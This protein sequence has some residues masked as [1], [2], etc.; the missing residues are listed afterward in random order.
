M[1]TTSNRAS[2]FASKKASLVCRCVPP[3]TGST[4]ILRLAITASKSRFD[5]Q[6]ISR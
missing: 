4:P 1:K 3:L 2:G 6:P 5:A